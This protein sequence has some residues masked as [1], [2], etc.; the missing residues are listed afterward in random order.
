M[1]TVFRICFITRKSHDGANT[2][3]TTNF[4]YLP[5]LEKIHIL[6]TTEATIFIRMTARVFIQHKQPYLWFIANNDRKMLW[7]YEDLTQTTTVWVLAKWFMHT[8]C[9]LQREQPVHRFQRK[10]L[11]SLC[12]NETTQ[13]T[14]FSI[15]NKNVLTLKTTYTTSSSQ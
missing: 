15:G 11:I 6:W 3:L 9:K 10:T 8:I 12:T 13:A 14:I 4:S 5:R 2:M 7:C 1:W